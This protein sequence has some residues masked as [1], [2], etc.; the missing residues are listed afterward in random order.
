MLRQEITLS[1]KVL[2]EYLERILYKAADRCTISIQ[3]CDEYEP[4]Y[5]STTE[6]NVYARTIVHFKTGWFSAAEALLYKNTERDWFF[7]YYHPSP[8]IEAFVAA[9]QRFIALGEHIPCNCSC[10]C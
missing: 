10:T 2:G 1:H 8:K 5:T 4:R 7:L 3:S 9:V 6:E